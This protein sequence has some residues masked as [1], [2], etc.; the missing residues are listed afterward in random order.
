M[1]R[2]SKISLIIIL[3]IIA[4]LTGWFLRP[5]KVIFVP[6]KTILKVDSVKVPVVREKIIYKSV[7]A[8]TEFVPF[9]VDNKIVDTI[10]K[11]P[12]FIDKIDTISKQKDTIK[13]WYH[14]PERCF[15]FSYLPGPD[16]IYEKT[17]MITQPVIK[18]ETCTYGI[19]VGIGYENG[20]KLQYGA[21][22]IW[23]FGGF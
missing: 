23:R 11:T 9:Y 6:G 22:L 5:Q 15:D 12:A 21:Y 3:L 1:N 18:K 17:I 13:I 10:F 19:G 16:S 20:F 7:P 4:F 14:F 8:K 2:S